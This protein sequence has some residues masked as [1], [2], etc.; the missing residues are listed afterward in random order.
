M[1]NLNQTFGQMRRAALEFRELQSGLS[2]LIE[3]S[4]LTHKDK[5]KAAGC[6][7]TH[8]YRKLKSKNFLTKHLLGMVRFI[9][10]HDNLQ[11]AKNKLSQSDE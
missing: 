7:S 1:E 8:Y 6:R 3:L 11:I 9:V 2:E 4:R 5:V 10:E